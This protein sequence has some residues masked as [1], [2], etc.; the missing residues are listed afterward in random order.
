MQDQVTYS[1]VD[2]YLNEVA[3]LTPTG[4][5]FADRLA[6]AFFGGWQAFASL[7]QNV[8]LAVVYLLPLI[9]VAAVIITL[10][11]VLGRRRAKRRPRRPGPMPPVPPA[12]GTG[13]E[14]TY[15]DPAMD[16]RIL[17]PDDSPNTDSGKPKPPQTGP[18]Y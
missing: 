18:K 14:A 6:D 3:T 17:M 1:T 2:I 12:S 8:F 4:V 10:C 15:M 11:V 16:D 13:P 5:T 9:L 7:V